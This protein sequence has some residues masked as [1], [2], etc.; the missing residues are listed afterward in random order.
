MNAKNI[1]VGLM[2]AS[3]AAAQ[4]DVTSVFTADNHYALYTDLGGVMTHVGGGE[5]GA[6]GAPG[7]YNWSQPETIAFDAGRHV[8]IAA[9]SDDSSAQGLIGTLQ[10]AGGAIHS[11]DARWEVFTTG[12]DLDSNSPAPTANEIAAQVSLAT[13]GELWTTPFVGASN[14]SA[15]QPWGQIAGIDDEANWM[16]SAPE[17]VDNPLNPGAN[18]GEYLIFRTVVPTPASAALIGCALLIAPRKRGCFQSTK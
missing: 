5:L 6:G 10:T 18:H 9:W 11:G 8:Y 15:P 2:L 7:Q 16:W 14:G 3:A 17:G 12:I 4:A 13:S 1:A